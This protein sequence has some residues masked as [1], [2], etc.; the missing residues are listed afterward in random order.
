[1][2][3]LAV[4]FVS[5]A[6]GHMET[7][8]WQNGTLSGCPPQYGVVFHE[9]RK[10]TVF[11]RRQQPTRGEVASYGQKTVLARLLHRRKMQIGVEHVNFHAAK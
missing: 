1:M 11:V 2:V 7:H 9:P 6:F 5:H 10:G 3:P 4:E 8:R